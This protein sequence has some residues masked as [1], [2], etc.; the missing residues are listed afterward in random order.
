M[1]P[2]WLRTLRRLVYCRRGHQW[3]YRR[4]NRRWTLECWRCL[5]VM[6]LES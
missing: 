3:I 1:T 5:S 4:A 2:W 6:S